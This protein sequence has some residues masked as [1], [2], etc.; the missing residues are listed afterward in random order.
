MTHGFVDLWVEFPRDLALEEGISMLEWA[1]VH[2]FSDLVI[3]GEGRERFVQYREGARALG[4][5]MTLHRRVPARLG[6]ES[7]PV[8][9]AVWGSSSVFMPAPRTRDLKTLARSLGEMSRSGYKPVI[10]GPELNP[11]IQRLPEL[12]RYLLAA[13]AICCGL[14]GSLMGSAGSGARFTGERLAALGYY[15]FI[16]GYVQARCPM[17]DLAARLG[18]LRPSW[19]RTQSRLDS[20]LMERG[21]RL[22]RER[23]RRH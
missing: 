11:E 14:A 1:R 23:G 9:S 5:G 19:R 3:V 21:Q 15:S 8:S 6:R 13:G 16:A 7:N 12:L 22:W 10:V 4:L 17:E 2:G 18:Q 20:V